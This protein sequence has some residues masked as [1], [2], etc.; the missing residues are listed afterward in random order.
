MSSANVLP[1]AQPEGETQSIYPVLPQDFRLGMVNEIAAALAHEVNH[2]RFVGKKYKRAKTV[3]NWLAGGAGVLSAA[4]SSASLGTALSVIGI[5]AA[6]PLGAVG[7]CFA[8]ASSGFV[9]I[10]KK[11]D[12][13][14]KTTS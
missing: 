8:L 6:V 14:I 7:G 13:K 1:S 10:S 9:I 11:L 2:Y 5:P 4:A 3:A 12:V